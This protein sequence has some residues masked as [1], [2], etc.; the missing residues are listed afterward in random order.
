ML[1]TC[2]PVDFEREEDQQV[3]LLLAFL[4]FLAIFSP[5]HLNKR[6]FST[7]YLIS[8]SRNRSIFITYQPLEISV[9][10]TPIKSQPRL[11]LP[12]KTIVVV[13]SGLA[14]YARSNAV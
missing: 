1:I 12:M 4:S 14:D 5:S 6:K 9:D 3:F 10:G 7:T 2:F 13:S 8:V 11:L